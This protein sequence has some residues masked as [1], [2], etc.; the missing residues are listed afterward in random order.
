MTMLTTDRAE[1]AVAA[2]LGA[3]AALDHTSDLGRALREAAGR[4]VPNADRYAAMVAL[5]EAREAL[6]RAAAYE[7]ERAAPRN[8]AAL[9]RAAGPLGRPLRTE[10]AAAW[11]LRQAAAWRELARAVALATI[12]EDRAAAAVAA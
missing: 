3:A 12:D 6:D 5:L 11:A 4:L 2:F 7:R 1:A 8:L 9:V 10:P